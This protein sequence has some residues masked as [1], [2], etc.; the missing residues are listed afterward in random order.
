MQRKK[1]KIYF[2]KSGCVGWRRGLAIDME[3][4]EAAG[5]G[6]GQEGAQWGNSDLRCFLDG[7]L[8]KSL[9]FS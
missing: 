3:R 6:I 8:D 5:Q 2:L 4:S 1:I 7:I 9:N